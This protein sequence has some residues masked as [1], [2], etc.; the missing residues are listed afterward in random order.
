MTIESDFA[1]DKDKTILS[2]NNWA[3]RNT[4][5]LIPTLID[6][7]AQLSST[8][9]SVLLNALFFKSSVKWQS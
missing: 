6:D 3:S 9:I 8:A 2:I 5:G 7:P 4:N 1:Q